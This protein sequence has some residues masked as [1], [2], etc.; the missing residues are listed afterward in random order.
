MTEVLPAQPV[1]R[2]KGDLA[3]LVADARQ[4]SAENPKSAAH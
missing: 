4:F 2:I 1:E 3:D